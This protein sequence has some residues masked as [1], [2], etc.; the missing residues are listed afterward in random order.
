MEEKKRVLEG[1]IYQIFSAWEAK[2]NKEKRILQSYKPLLENTNF[3]SMEFPQEDYVDFLRHR[4]LLGGQIRRVMEKLRLL[5]NITGEDFKHESGLLDLQE[6]IQIVASKSRRTDI[7]VREELQTSEQ[8]WAVLVD[9]SHSLNLAMTTVRGIALCLGEVAKSIIQDQR[10]WGMFA[11]NNKFYI[12]KD[13][14]ENYTAS[15]HARIGGLSYSGMTYL[16][17]GISVMSNM[18][19]RRSEQCK[20]LMVVSDF[21][22]SGYSDIEQKLAKNVTMAERLGVGVIGIGV[23]SRAVKNYFRFNCVVDTPYDLMKKF[24]KIFIQYSATA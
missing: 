23:K 10:A 4:A 17:D 15:S 3:Q 2:K 1:E 18:L 13:F 8:A 20:I 22:P 9:A 7:F 24:T 11:F 6:A 5:K 14:S 19:R 12:I 21:F 16:P